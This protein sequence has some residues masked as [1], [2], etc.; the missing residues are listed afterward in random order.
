M[1][2]AKTAMLILAIICAVLGVVMFALV[3]V[4]D[5]LGAMMTEGASEVDAMAGINNIIEKL[6]GGLSGLTDFGALTSNIPAMLML[7]GGVIAV[8]LFVVAFVLSIVKKHAKSL[9]LLIPSA[10]IVAVAA[11]AGKIA[12]SEFDFG[13]MTQ[14]AEVKYVA[15]G[16]VGVMAAGVV[17]GILGF[18]FA[19]LFLAKIKVEKKAKVAK[20]APAKAEEPV[21]AKVPEETVIAVATEKAVEPVV[22]EKVQ[23]EEGAEQVKVVRRI[24]VHK[25]GK[26]VRVLNE[27]YFDV[28][29]NIY[30]EPGFVDESMPVETEA[31]HY[32][33]IINAQPKKVAPAPAPVAPTPAPVVAPAPVVVEKAKIERIP[34]PVRMKSAEKSLKLAYNEIKSEILSY[35]IKSRISS[36]GDTFRLHTKTYVKVVIAGKSLKLYFALDPKAY[37]DSTFPISDASKKVAHKETPLVFKV[38]SDLSIRRA[39][40]LIAD[41]AAVDKLVQGEVVKHDHAKEVK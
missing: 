29:T 39:K 31:Q 41:C 28:T 33:K 26:V 15:Y 7:I 20:E 27:H 37:K 25:S 11:I 14:I 12:L 21:A 8:V 34:F 19:V 30:V 32:E 5:M 35:G 1:K 36:T 10:V 6:Q 2:K 40:Q 24:L 16:A 17:F 9:G 4:F 22:T 38:K 18:L 13:T 3:P 23:A